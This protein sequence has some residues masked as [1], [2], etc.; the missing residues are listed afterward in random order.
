MNLVN[1]LKQKKSQIFIFDFISS[2]VILIVAIVIVL[3]YFQSTSDNVDIYGIN[4]EIID[5][6]TTT[7][8]N[9]LN[10]F[11]VRDLF[12]RGLITNIENTI[13]QQ[14]SEFHYRGAD[15]N[16]RNLTRIFVQDFITQQMNINVTLYDEVHS[17]NIYSDINKEIEFQNAEIS[18]VTER[19][20][21]G[22]YQGDKYTY[23][24]KIELWQ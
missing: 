1:K 15:S 11:E 10:N 23:T 22:T 9:E 19:L 20:V 14:V 4:A 5:I 16:S 21:F 24:F 18:S 17:F 3:S 2:F 7:K 8:I 6:Y 13:A 12:V